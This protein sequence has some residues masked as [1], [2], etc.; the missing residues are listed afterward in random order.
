MLLHDS[1]FQQ[2]I[3]FVQK[4]HSIF[5]LYIHSIPTWVEHKII[6]VKLEHVEE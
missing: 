5:C 6:I 3:L 1:T 4:E 2:M